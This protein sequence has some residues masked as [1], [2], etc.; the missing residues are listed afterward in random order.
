LQQ[1]L[2]PERGVRICEKNDSADTKVSEEGGA[3]GAPGARAEIPLQPMKRTMVRKAV[4]PQPMQV[5]GGARYPPAAQ[6]GPHASA[7]GRAQ[8]RL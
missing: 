7:G 3:G 8:R 4:L 6:R 1:Q 5:H 2:Q